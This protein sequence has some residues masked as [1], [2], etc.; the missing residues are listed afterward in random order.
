[1]IKTA[2]CC[3]RTGRETPNRIGN[4]EINLQTPGFWQ[5]RQNHT[6][7]KT[8]LFNQGWQNWVCTW[9]RRK[10]DSY[11]SPCRRINLRWIKDLDVKIR[12]PR[13]L[14][15]SRGTTQGSGVRKNFLTRTPA[16][17]EPAPSTN[18]WDSGNKSRVQ[19]RKQQSAQ[20]I[21]QNGWQTL[22]ALLQTG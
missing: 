11:L 17:W 12:M 14:D 6:L 19:R 15:T 16:A 1:M 18:S 22:T 13:L 8:S 5:R 7:E 4:P 2:W 20:G 3:S 21:S 9:G 10:L